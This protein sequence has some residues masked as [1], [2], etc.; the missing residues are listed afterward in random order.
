MHLKVFLK[1]SSLLSNLR[2]TSIPYISECVGVGADV[3][4]LWETKRRINL[5]FK[6]TITR[7]N[8]TSAELK[9]KKPYGW[10]STKKTFNSRN[11]NRFSIIMDRIPDA[12]DLTRDT[13]VVAMYT[14][15]NLRFFSGIILSYSKVLNK[16]Q[17]RYDDNDRAYIKREGIRLEVSPP[18]PFCS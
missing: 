9:M 6:A 2:I 14:S 18:L 12:N 13:R 8:K 16:Y 7:L 1:S 11:R 3:L 4:G 17:I 15:D 10:Y 5:Y